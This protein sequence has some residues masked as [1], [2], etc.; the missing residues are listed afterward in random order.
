MVCVAAPVLTLCSGCCSLPGGA[1]AACAC[2]QGKLE[3]ISVS[4][5]AVMVPYYKPPSVISLWV[6]DEIK[7]RKPKHRVRAGLEC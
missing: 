4:A 5:G 1:A 2:A 3:T 6:T 7:T